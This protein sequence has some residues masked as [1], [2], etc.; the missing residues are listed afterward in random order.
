MDKKLIMITL[1]MLTIPW[2]IDN[3]TVHKINSFTVCSQPSSFSGHY[4]IMGHHMHCFLVAKW[5][6]RKCL[7]HDLIEYTWNIPSQPTPASAE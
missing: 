7:T 4:F 2:Q 3:T 1:C 6:F 5:D